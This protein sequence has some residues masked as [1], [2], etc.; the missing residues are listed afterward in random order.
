MAKT[1][2]DYGKDL[3]AIAKRI[4]NG[5]PGAPPNVGTVAHIRSLRP[6]GIRPCGAVP[7]S[8]EQHTR[9]CSRAGLPNRRSPL[10]GDAPHHRLGRA[11]SFVVATADVGER[12]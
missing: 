4:D 5:V 7:K 8:H 11:G 6:L 12:G 1:E 10:T 2:E 3:D 9:D